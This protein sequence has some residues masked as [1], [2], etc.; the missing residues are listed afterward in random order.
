MSSGEDQS[1]LNS[2][3]KLSISS[4]NDN[5]IP[6]SLKNYFLPSLYTLDLQINHTKP[7]FQGELSIQLIKN[8]QCNSV[9]ENVSITLH[10]KNLILTQTHLSSSNLENSIKLSTTYNRQYHTVTLS[11]SLPD[12]ISISELIDPTIS[13]KYMGQI[14]TIKTYKDATTGLFKTNYLDNVAGNANNYILATHFQPNFAKLVFPL[15]E[16]TN[17]KVPIKL[18]IT[19]LSKF[20]VLSNQSLESN[21]TLNMSE[22]SKFIFKTTPPISSSVFG[23]IIGDFEFVEDKVDHIPIRIYTTI[24]DSI[25]AY[26]GLKVIKKIL[27]L[28]IQK[29]GA[30][31][32]SK[33]DFITLPF[34]N[35]GAME[36][37]GMIT[38]LSN[39]LL[40]NEIEASNKQKLQIQQLISHELIHQWLGNAVSFDD[41]RYLWLNESFATFLGNYFVKNI[42]YE[43][44]QI[45]MVESFMDKDSF[46]GNVGS[47]Q[48]YMSKINTGLSAT[49][50]TIFETNSYEKGIIILRMIAIM[51]KKD[52]NYDD[53]NYNELLQGLKSFFEKYNNK[54]IKPFEIW[55][56]LNEL[57]SVDLLSFFHSYLQYEGFPLVKVSYPQQDKLHIE[58]HRFINDSTIDQLQLEDYP[59]HVP[60]LL[61]IKDSNGQFKIL[62]ILLTDRS[63]DLD[64]PQCQLININHLK[65][66]YYRALYEFDVKIFDIDSNDLISILHDYGKVLLYSIHGTNVELIQFIN[67]LIQFTDKSWT[68]DWKV[69]KV[70]LTYLEL[71]NNTLINFTAYDEFKNLWLKSFLKKIYEKIGHWDDLLTIN[72]DKYSS[73]EFEVRN[74]IL[75][76]ALLTIEEP[77]LKSNIEKLVSK[78]FKSFLNSS[79]SFIPHQLL[80]SIFIG[81]IKQNNVQDYKKILE[82]VKN[83]NTSL[84][85]HTNLSNPNE[86]QT[87]ALSSLAFVTSEEL[88]NKTLNF[89]MTN[90]DS[91]LIE[92]SLIGFQYKPAINDRLRLFNWYKLHYDQWILKSL[93]K[94]SEWS[95]Q[96]GNT[97]KNLSTMVLGEIMQKN[98]SQLQA[99]TKE[100]ISTKLTSLPNHDLKSLVEE[101]NESNTI[102]IHIANDI[103][104]QLI[105]FLAANPLK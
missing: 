103:Y 3:E 62:N 53:E 30:Y 81:T 82:L 75:T 72:R 37:W 25:N 101:I 12:T 91:K 69:L 6:L 66:G 15:I 49:T 92:L 41:W 47:I 88:I 33:L 93:R 85:N 87:I 11:C 80:S 42:N 102:R 59:F 17:M 67:I 21:Q 44:S 64:I 55:S 38:V 5:S 98:S 39:Q 35:D 104:P 8:D 13:I 71:L 95:K 51:L 20:K 77:K 96:L 50:S 1:V 2:V 46:V 58:Q 78:L 43:S 22:N 73:H 105:T 31:P 40:I 99:L 63:I 68:V 28:M 24:G 14:N 65:G 57:T 52:Q 74:S 36:N 60:L 48:S 56:E 79:K 16:E 100:F 54:V 29:F 7:N 89:M 76:L 97:M 9:S 61:K 94:G 45:D 23:F 86:L 10:S 4:N 18:S 26:Y 70:A 83:S 84:L 90:I 27:P 34:L 19:T 32:L